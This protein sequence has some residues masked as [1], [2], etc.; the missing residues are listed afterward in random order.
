[1]RLMNIVV[2]NEG[3][4]LVVPLFMQGIHIFSEAYVLSLASCGMVLGLTWL[5]I[6]GP[7]LW[8][9]KELTMQFVLGVES[10][11]ILSP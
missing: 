6:L 1:M 10:V 11:T 2:G 4:V 9:F 7:I 3:W 8:N 5:Q